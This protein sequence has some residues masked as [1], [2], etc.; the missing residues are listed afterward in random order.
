MA[1]FAAK[2]RT[3]NKGGASPLQ[4][5][6]GRSTTIPGSWTCQISSGKMPFK[7]N[8]DLEANEALAQAE[9]IRIGAVE[10]YHRLD[11]HEAL[12][13]ALAFR[14]TPPKL[15]G[16]REGAVVYV[17]DPPACGVIHFVGVNVPRQGC[18][19]IIFLDLKPMR[20]SFGFWIPSPPCKSL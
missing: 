10:A 7:Y 5:V 11:S 13:R 19:R 17:Y 3:A 16:I 6:T 12:R 4:A 14:S 9:R 1:S 8:Q 15:E 20:L 18:F 2:N